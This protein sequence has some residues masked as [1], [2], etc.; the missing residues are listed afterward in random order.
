[1]KSHVHRAPQSIEKDAI[2]STVHVYYMYTVVQRGLV[3]L[4]LPLTHVKL[5]CGQVTSESRV[6]TS[7]SSVSLY[8][9]EPQLSWLRT[10][11]YRAPQSIEKEI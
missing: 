1:M 10:A 7:Y 2:A 8:M 3:G 9:I 6:L 4:N 11:V 5:T